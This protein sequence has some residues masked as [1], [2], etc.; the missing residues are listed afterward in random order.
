MLTWQSHASLSRA[1][2]GSHG[3]I[4]HG[5]ID[6]SSTDSDQGGELLAPWP[7]EVML[8]IASW[9]LTAAFAVLFVRSHWRL[10]LVARASHELRNPLSAVQLGLA[11]LTGEP[12][13]VAALE[14]EL[15]RAGRALED[16]AAAPSGR[17]ADSATR[18]VDLAAF[19][20]EYEPAWR[21]LA[22]AFGSELRVEA[23]GG[24]VL[25]D[26]LRLAQAC[27]NLIG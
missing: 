7:T 22:A 14:L 10:V 18:P 25:G 3:C 5:R 13:R 26:P 16:L 15:A 23:S 17:R 9:F 24:V 2:R 27:S 21:S 6:H 20:S 4:R 1:A 11:A 12:A 19:V 8:M